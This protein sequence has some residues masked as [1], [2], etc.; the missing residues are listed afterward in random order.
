MLKK[1]T[2]VQVTKELLI[3]ALDDE[4]RVFEISLPKHLMCCGRF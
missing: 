4:H 3:Q 1:H 2:N